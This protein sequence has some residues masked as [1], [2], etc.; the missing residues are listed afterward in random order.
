QQRGQPT[1]APLLA[2]ETHGRADTV[3]AADP[4]HEVDTGDT[5]G[6]FSAIYPVR[7]KSEAPHQ[8]SAEIAS[9]PGHGID[10]GLLRYLRA[11]TAERLSIHPE[12]QVLLNYLGRVHLGASGDALRLD[13]ALLAD[14]SPVPEPNYAVHHELTLMAAVIDHEGTT[15]LGVQWR[16]VPDILGADDIGELQRLWEAQLREVV[17]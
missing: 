5:V 14:A 12:P 6:L 9:I 2:L 13:G 17:K 11:E 15:A 7:I 16:T 1:P 3:V 10:F 8:V 4:E